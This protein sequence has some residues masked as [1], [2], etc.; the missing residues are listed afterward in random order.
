MNVTT[1]IE[2]IHALCYKPGWKFEASDHTKRFEGSVKVRITYPAQNSDREQAREGYPTNITTYAEFALIVGDLL[3]I[4]Q[5]LR[6]FIEALM[7]IE[8]HETREFLRIQ[9][10][11]SAPFHPHTIDGMRNWHKSCTDNN[12]L[13]DVSSDMQFGVA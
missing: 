4:N 13:M 6:R 11:F 1:A 7:K 5:L 3:E 12:L 2:F 9:G 8:L 10:T